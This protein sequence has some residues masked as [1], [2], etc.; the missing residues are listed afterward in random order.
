MR[1]EIEIDINLAFFRQLLRSNREGPIMT[2]STEAMKDT[3]LDKG[4]RVGNFHEYY[5]FNPP[6]NRL[7]VLQ[8]CGILEY[9]KTTVIKHDTITQIARER[10]SKRIK[11]DI[12][13]QHVKLDHTLAYCDLGCNEGDLSLALSKE[14]AEGLQ[15][16]CSL[17]CLGLD[18]DKELIDRARSKKNCQQDT[19]DESNHPDKISSDVRVEAEFQVCNL[20]DE[21]DHLTKCREYLDL[22]GKERFDL[23]SVFSTTMWIHIHSGDEGL[24]A[25]LKRVTSLT[26]HLLIEPQPSKCYGKVNV[27]LRKM[28]R[29][30]EDISLER[31]RMRNNIE[32]EIDKLLEEFGFERVVL[33]AKASTEGH[34]NS[35]TKWK[36]NLQMYKR[37]NME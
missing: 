27:R 2:S 21:A 18:I 9:I 23:T 1:I 31:L 34:E 8:K 11:L 14:M 29:P 19:G 28:N 32:V 25:F 33:D 12:N 13:E 30:E 26:N 10:D 7:D 16:A 6:M 5:K 36:R 20:N 37:K 17:H 15:T 24:V 35:R 22:A 3:S 4:H